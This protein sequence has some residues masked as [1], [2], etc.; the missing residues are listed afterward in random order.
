MEFQQISVWQYFSQRLLENGNVDQSDMSHVMR[1]P[2][3]AIC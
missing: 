1:K 3:F 2:V